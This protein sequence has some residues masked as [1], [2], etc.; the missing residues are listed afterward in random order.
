M[1]AGRSEI[2]AAAADSGVVKSLVMWL[3]NDYSSRAAYEASEVLT[4][5]TSQA[6]QQEQLA[7]DPE[8]LQCLVALIKTLLQASDAL[9]D[10]VA[11][12][13][14]T[15]TSVITHDL[16][17]AQP[18]M[19]NLS[20][21]KISCPSVDAA[22]A[23]VT[24]SQPV[25]KHLVSRSASS[26]AAKPASPVIL[27]LP[28]AQHSE[29]PVPQP[30]A[31]AAASD[32]THLTSALLRS[33]SA[34]APAASV[35]AEPGH[36]THRFLDGQALQTSS[37][38]VSMPSNTGRSL[39]SNWFG[40]FL[41]RLGSVNSR[42]SSQADVSQPSLGAEAGLHTCSGLPAAISPSLSAS[43]LF[44]GELAR[45]QSIKSDALSAAAM[46]KRRHKPRRPSQTILKVVAE[47]L[48]NLLSRNPGAQGTLI[49][50]GAVGLSQDVLTLA[51]SVGLQ[52]G[53]ASA[54][55][56][57]VKSLSSGNT[58]A[59]EAF[60]RAGSIG[61]LVSFLLVWQDA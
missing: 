21:L 32:P 12:E 15:G 37:S 23:S 56:D 41:K 43:T 24:P 13:N 19:S 34:A 33:Q 1:H 51:G 6:H 39:K 29:I 4:V 44:S 11:G 26:V 36:L 35:S 59:Q 16:S 27:T 54:G 17:P 22:S 46:A 45:S 61:Q 8:T 53:L 50:G 38:G 52:T 3:Q 48:A 7:Y 2:I 40:S 5:L 28:N 9:S 30:P 58:T 25:S 42:T 47:A 55:A 60:G 18:P 57:L 31:A 20:A 10:R 49:A 14:L